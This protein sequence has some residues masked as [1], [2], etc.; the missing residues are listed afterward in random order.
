ML[1][2][3]DGLPFGTKAMA[4]RIRQLLVSLTTMTAANKQE[5]VDLI[6]GVINQEHAFNLN[7]IY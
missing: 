3:K 4:S 7:G 6:R 2:N 5:P 1:V